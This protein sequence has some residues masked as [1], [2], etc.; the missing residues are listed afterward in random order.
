M[1]L[2][3]TLTR[4]DRGM[5]VSIINT[6]D[7]GGAANAA[8]RLHQGL[9]S[10]NVDSKLIV[11]RGREAAEGK[12]V[13]AQ[14]PI[15]T[16]LAQSAMRL[17][18]SQYRGLDKSPRSKPVSTCELFSDCR[19]ANGVAL[20]LHPAEIDILNLH[21][22]ARFV[23]LPSLVPRFAGGVPIVWTLHDMQPL[24]GGCHYTAGCES[25]LSAC[26]NCP[27]LI[28]PGPRDASAEVFQARLAALKHLGDSD[29][30]IVAPSKWLL[31]EA[32]R[33][34]ALSRF[35][36]TCIPYGLDTDSFRP[37]NKNLARQSLGLPLDKRLLLF[38]SACVQ[39]H[40][41]GLD[42]LIGA[43]A[44]VRQRHPDLHVVA[45]GAREKSGDDPF[46]ELDMITLGTLTDERRLA[47]AYS[48]ADL[49]V[50][51]SRQDNLPNTMLE[52]IACGTPVVGFDIGGIPDA[53][54][55][56]KTGWLAKQ[57]SHESLA[58]AISEA[59]LAMQDRDLVA[60]YQANCRQIAETEF[61]LARQ[62]EDYCKL[63][64]SL[65]ERQRRSVAA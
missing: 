34:A 38:V 45:V 12:I 27:Q 63:F 61:A 40:R 49:F 21:W 48:A 31:K 2:S 20:K 43:L 1:S 60:R 23:D 15:A 62:A 22:V 25:F 54:R 37:I 39:N 13:R 47:A 6:E 4:T 42:L 5:K 57:L 7:R 51:P 10:L 18:L 17:F 30:H 9:L 41:K 24:T 16:T 36:R 11:Y 52:S 64:R 53:V 55:P 35:S 3:R 44:Q 33:S 28:T 65:V 14:K 46:S 29:L 19:S 50:I 59:L 58:A 32:A 56:G 26:Q 8:I